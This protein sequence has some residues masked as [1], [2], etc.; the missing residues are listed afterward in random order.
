MQDGTSER[1]G[2]LTL[3]LLTD[4]FGYLFPG[5]AAAMDTPPPYEYAWCTTA[6]KNDCRT[7]AALTASIVTSTYLCDSVPKGPFCQIVELRGLRLWYGNT[8]RFRR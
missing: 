5:A 4:S 3:L 2:F 1:I 8:I 6:M 7:L